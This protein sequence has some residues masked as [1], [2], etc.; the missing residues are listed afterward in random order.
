MNLAF[1]STNAALGAGL[2]MDA[3]SSSLA[4]GLAEPGMKKTRACG[5]ALL[6]AFFQAAMPFLGWSLVRSFLSFFHVLQR[7]I[8]WLA[9]TLLTW[10]GTKMLIDGSEKKE[11]GAPDRQSK[12]ISVETLLMQGL[13]TSLDA[14]SVGFTLSGYGFPMAL[15]AF[16]LIGGVTFFLCLAGIFLGKRFGVRLAGGASILGGVIL[17][18]IGIEIYIL[19]L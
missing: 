15:G 8:P 10:I 14:L 2:A 18:L 7:W 19:S 1:V 5:I 6:F 11:D 17:I 3:F 4:N 9:L 13:A 12:R 16:L